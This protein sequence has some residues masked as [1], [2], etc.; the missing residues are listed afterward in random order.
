MQ[1]AAHFAQPAVLSLCTQAPPLYLEHLPR[2]VPPPPMSQPRRRHRSTYVCTF[3]KRRKVRCD[4]GSPCSTCV[5]YK[6]TKCEYIPDVRPNTK[7]SVKSSDIDDMTQSLSSLLTI[8][9]ARSLSAGSISSN[10]TFGNGSSASTYANGSSSYANGSAG[11][12]GN[13]SASYSN[14]SLIL[15]P[16]VHL[17]LEMLKQKINFLE[18]LVSY[19]RSHKAPPS[20]VPWRT[21]TDLIQT[22]M[23][24]H[25]PCASETEMFSFHANYLP[26]LLLGLQPS[27]FCAPLSWIAL[28]KI[29]N[30]VSPMFAYKHKNVM[31]KR[32]LAK[33]LSR[34]SETLKPSER[35]FREK[36][37]DEASMCEGSLL[38]DSRSIRNPKDIAESRRQLNEKARAVGLTVFEGD[39]SQTHDT[40]DKVKLL[41]PTMKVIWML[42]E[43]FFK[44]VYPFFPFLDQFDF[45]ENIIRILGSESRAHTKVEKLHID[46]K[47]DLVYLALLLMVLRF[48]YLTL[49]TNSDA[50]NEANLRTN[51]PSQRAQEIKFLM[52]NPID[53]D[54]VD[55]AHLCLLLFGYVRTGNLRLLQL[56]LFMKLYYSFAPENGDTPEDTNA[57]AYTALLLNMAIGLGM[58]REPDNFENKVRDEKTNNL[59]RKIW[60]YLLIVDLQGGMSNGLAPTVNRDMFDTSP[61]YFKPGNENVRDIEVEKEA[62]NALRSIDRC[63]DD[64]NLVLKSI[65]SI[66]QPV[67]LKDLCEKLTTL[68]I[69]YIKNQQPFSFEPDALRLVPI[70]VTQAIGTKIYFQA[71]FFLLSICFHLFNH[72]ERSN[73]IELAYFYLK[74][75]VSVAICNTMPFYEDFVDKSHIWF[76]NSTDLTVTPSFQALIHKCMIVIQ[77]LMARARFS[78]LQCETL[79]NHMTHLVS[80]LHYRR[81]YDLLVETYE[82]CDKC[83]QCFVDTLSKLSSR[84]YYSWRCV[85]ANLG[86]RSAREG[87]DF[88]LKFCKGRE[89]YFVFPQEMHEDLN[90]VL[91][92]ALELVKKNQLEKA[93]I[94][95]EVLIAE[96]VFSGDTPCP[97]ANSAIPDTPLADIDSLWMQMMTMKPQMNKS[98]MFSRTPPTFDL[99]VGLGTFDFNGINFEDNML[100]EENNFGF[101]EP[102]FDDAIRLDL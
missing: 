95:N 5:K 96:D 16:V 55:V 4:K 87:T 24:G 22:S 45:E 34:D 78:R 47:L 42:I 8:S 91:K 2:L 41:L 49:F 28:V 61:P 3:C 43:R 26:F 62:V 33:E 18:K 90:N 88:Y 36:I 10:S 37:T 75:V 57:Q 102:T 48:G 60:Y 15:T 46:K 73:Q 50:I 11:L 6:N 54:F 81:R 1:P 93:A 101:F 79:P 51:D 32:M 29:D 94:E 77:A 70:D 71:N 65:S 99:D 20:P 80:D 69:E 82:L 19:P 23:L 14:D 72:Y 12:Y 30:S 27:R 66:S 64:L 9:T 53:I 21:S 31:V 98:I 13:G 17:E 100:A 58:H 56:A 7:R 67:N 38:S 52:H 74:K 97:H 83:I 89:G 85:K 86:L 92:S 59:C 25:N 40:V 44:R 76:Q 68:E 39:L 35:L 63:Y 84:Y